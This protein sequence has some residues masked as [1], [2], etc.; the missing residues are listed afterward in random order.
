M[1]RRHRR[2][3]FVLV[4]ALAIAW[5]I[6]IPDAAPHRRIAV[7]QIQRFTSGGDVIISGID[8]AYLE[9]LLGDSPPRRIIPISRNV[10]YAS[11]LIALQP[12]G[13]LDPPPAGWRAT[14]NRGLARLGAVDPI[15]ITAA[16]QLGALAEL[17][18]RNRRL[19][20]ETSSI[21][22]SDASILDLIRKACELTPVAPSLFRLNCRP[23]SQAGRTGPE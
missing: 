11:K 19:F 16:D 9:I 1:W 12:V 2:L 14:R 15:P 20:L 4:L 3:V 5:R 7:E 13:R 23:D 17:A 6:M 8:P 10:E 21:A 22:G 18:P